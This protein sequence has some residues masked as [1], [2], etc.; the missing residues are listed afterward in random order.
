M[1]FRINVFVIAI[2]ISNLFLFTSILKLNVNIIA[3]IF[4]MI[5]RH[6]SQSFE[7]MTW[8]LSRILRILRAQLWSPFRFE[9]FLLKS[10]NKK[11]EKKNGRKKERKKEITRAHDC[12]S[13]PFWASSKSEHFYCTRCAYLSPSTFKISRKPKLW[14]NTVPMTT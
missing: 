3:K 8:N 6:G 2:S 4:S 13:S 12:H 9:I 1:H 5:Y 7:S 11:E 10:F 14:Q